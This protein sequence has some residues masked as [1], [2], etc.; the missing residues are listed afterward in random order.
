MLNKFPTKI[1]VSGLLTA[2]STSGSVFADTIE[3]QGTLRDFSSNHSDFEGKVTGHKTGCVE[4]TLGQDGKPVLVK[5]NKCAITQ[6]GDWYNETEHSQSM[7]FTITLEMDKKGDTYAYTNNH[8]YPIDEQLLGNEGRKHNFHFTYELHAQF[9]YQPGQEFRFQGDDGVW[10]FINNELVVDIGGVKGAANRGIK[11]DGLGFSEGETY[12]FS[13]F[14]AE[15]HTNDSKLDI[16]MTLGTPSDSGDEGGGVVITPL[17]KPEL[18]E[19]TTPTDGSQWHIPTDCTTPVLTFKGQAAMEAQPR[20]LDLVLVIDRSGSTERERRQQREIPNVLEG[21]RIAANALIDMLESLDNVRLSLVSFSKD[22][23]L[24]S[25]LTDDW[26]S[27]RSAITGITTPVG[28]TNMA[29]A[30]DKALTTL[31]DVDSETQKNIILMTDGIPTLPFGSGMTQESED[32]QAT[33]EA[34]YRARDAGVRIYPVVIQPKDYTGK[35]T[36]MP[37]V[38]AI[39]GVPGTIEQLSMDNLDQLGEALTHISLTDVTYVDVTNIA[40]GVTVVAEIILDGHFQAN[41]PMQTGDNELK[42]TAHAGNPDNATELTIIVPVGSTPTAGGDALDCRNDDNDDDDN[43]DGN[44]DDSGSNSDDSNPDN[45]KGKKVTICH[46][47]PGN[48]DNP[49]TITISENAV[50]A[51]LD[52]GDHEGA[53]DEDDEKKNKGGKK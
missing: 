8:F 4:N 15:R 32:R 3:L 20:P 23:T 52:H 37:A 22:A 45:D 1:L 6:M 46:I 50:Q 27:L 9:T 41:V 12:Q 51:H 40:L 29:A 28:G 33:L 43:K 31:V 5:N 47:P 39:T 44:G 19:L 24:E 25:P 2:L 11:V 35:L 34:A 21:E 53:C 13:L 16:S 36:T 49:Q 18:L 38:Q 7:P 14:G 48:E 10:V 17:P 26:T 42:I 30:I